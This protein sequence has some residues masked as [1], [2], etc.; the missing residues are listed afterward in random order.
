MVMIDKGYLS[1]VN[2]KL[3]Y[4]HYSEKHHIFVKYFS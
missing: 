3:K 2:I 4:S 1:V